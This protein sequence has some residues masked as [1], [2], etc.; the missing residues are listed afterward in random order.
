MKFNFLIVPFSF[1]CPFSSFWFNHNSFSLIL[2]NSS[3]FG[4]VFIIDWNCPEWGKWV[5]FMVILVMCTSLLILLARWSLI[6]IFSELFFHSLHPVLHPIESLV[7]KIL[8]GPEFFRLLLE[9]FFELSFYLF[10]GLSYHIVNAIETFFHA[11]ILAM[12]DCLDGDS[13]WKIIPTYRA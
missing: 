1:F 13:F 5:Y 11:L 8:V 6:L 7:R 3:K 9:L 10:S 2:S 12:E 4:R